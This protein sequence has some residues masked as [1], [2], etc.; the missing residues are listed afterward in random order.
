M[1]GMTKK[2]MLLFLYMP[3][4]LNDNQNKTIHQKLIDDIV[5]SKYMYHTLT[6]WYGFDV[7]FWLTE[8]G[9]VLDWIIAEH[10]DYERQFLAILELM[11]EKQDGSPHIIFIKQ[12]DWV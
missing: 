5:E 12:S 2:N 4:K 11:L 7:Y 6:T 10:K 8:M 9:I 3:D 1:D